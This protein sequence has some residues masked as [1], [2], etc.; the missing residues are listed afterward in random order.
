MLVIENWRKGMLKNYLKTAFRVLRRARVYSAVNIVGLALGLATAILIALWVQNEFSYDRYNVNADRIYR[1]TSHWVY[2]NGDYTMPWTAGPL[3][4]AL[5]Q[6]PQV[7][8]AARLSMP[9]N[10]VVMKY[11]GEMFNM[12]DFFYT[13]PDFFRMFTFKMLEGNPQTALSAPY[14]IVLTKSVAGR[15][16]GNEEPIGK[17]VDVKAEDVSHDFLVTGVVE[18]IPQNS[19]FHPKC[20]ASYSS[21]EKHDPYL[22]S[23]YSVGL[24]T[25]FMLHRNSSVQSVQHELPLIVKQYLG[26]W[27]EEQKWTFGLQKLTD[28]H[29][30][31][32]L[33]GEIEPNGSIESVFIFGAI[34]FFILLISLIN[35]ISLS[36][37]RFSDRAKEVGVRKVIGA[38]RKEVIAQ[39]ISEGIVL[40]F[41]A[42]VLSISLCELLLPYFNQLTGEALSLSLTDLAIAVTAVLVLG[43]VAGIYPAL[44]LSSFRPTSIFRRDPLLNPS[45][46]PLRKGLVVLQFAIAVGIIAS[47]IVAAEQLHYVQNKNL[48]FNKKNLV[49][50]SSD[51]KDLKGSFSAFRSE[52]ESDPQ[53]AGVCGA[54]FL[55]AAE[56]RAVGLFKD[57]LDPSRSGT[58]EFMSVDRGFIDT[59]GMKMAEGKTFSE[60]TP[61]ESKDAVILNQTAV[62]AFNI[63]NP[64]SQQFNGERIIGVVGDFNLHS[65]REKVPPV[66]I[67]CNADYVN[68]VAVRVR[69]SKDTRKVIS[70]VEAESKRF[71]GGRPME[72]QSFGDRLKDMYGSDYKFAD[73]IGY[74]TGLAIFVACL[75]LF[76]V[77]LFAAERRVKE[78]GIRK[79]VGA[80]S[81]NIVGLLT[82]EF[83]VLS[84]ISAAISMPVMVYI[85]EDWLRNYAYHVN[86]NVYSAVLTL[87]AALVIVSLTVGYRAVR[88]ATANPVE[89]LRY[90]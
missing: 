39:F 89:S 81:S 85:M 75:G 84:L 66:V 11:G 79:V 68:E 25:Y 63:K 2:G 65:L 57:K 15:L 23:W 50:F 52:L 8:C 21:V 56:S 77:S 43:V 28:I 49:V 20:L 64:L 69:S 59:M 9:V 14:S 55:P 48:G 17:L 42:G 82:K 13:D 73:M 70:F 76:G 60:V 90:E 4:N 6:L 41:T 27:G 3:A 37:A 32:H 31:S 34:G 45:G 46:V 53:I 29:L 71:N 36:V 12:S 1:V 33:I 22:A 61:E 40:T 87:V 88:T 24:Y 78:I 26:K 18:D 5:S 51:P 7:K 10:N 35:F 74:F 83:V 19:Q 58:F 62:R 86:F 38:R 67:S 47:T 16:F 30:H 54:Q 72:Y 80:S 44:F